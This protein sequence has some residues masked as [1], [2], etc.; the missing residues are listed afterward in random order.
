[1]G[2]ALNISRVMIEYIESNDSLYTILAE[3]LFYRLSHTHH[4]WL[5]AD[6]S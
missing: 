2:R 4:Q 5:H 1:M 3:D 6:H